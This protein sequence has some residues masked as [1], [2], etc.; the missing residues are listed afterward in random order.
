V[1]QHKLTFA[2]E[3]GDIYIYHRT[4]TVAYPASWPVSRAALPLH[5]HWL[6]LL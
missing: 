5:R 3:R 2:L 6:W 4:F 1:F